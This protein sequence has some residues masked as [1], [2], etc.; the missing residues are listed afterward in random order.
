MLLDMEMSNTTVAWTSYY[1]LT[2]ALQ[3]LE[4]IF[5]AGAVEKYLHAFSIQ[6]VYGSN[7]TKINVNEPQKEMTCDNCRFSISFIWA[8]KHKTDLNKQLNKHVYLSY[9]LC[10]SIP[11]TVCYL[12]NLDIKLSEMNYEIGHNMNNK[13]HCAG[14]ESLKSVS[15][16]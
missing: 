13:R 12:Y 7:K 6:H 2:T 5:S 1:C 9:F 14:L 4:E 11:E 3:G 10:H 16:R 8:V 15:G